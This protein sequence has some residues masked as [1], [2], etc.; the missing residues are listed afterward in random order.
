[1]FAH[2]KVYHVDVVVYSCCMCK[3][4]CWACQCAPSFVNS[5]TDA[6]ISD[7]RHSFVFKA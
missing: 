7:G 4:C 5:V 3:C 6:M 2:L 1:M